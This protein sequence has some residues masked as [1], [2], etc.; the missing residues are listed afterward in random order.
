MRL[1]YLSPHYPRHFS[2]FPQ[3][4]ARY[5]VQVLGVS[6][7]PDECLE[8]SLRSALAGHYRVDGLENREQV[9]TA[10]HFFREHFGPFDRV[11]S[12]LEPWL[13]ME[14]VIREVFQVTGPK[15]ADLEFL[16]RKS[17]MKKVFQDARV[18][19]AR[20]TIVETIEQ[21][22][23]FIERRYPVFIKP[24]IG[25]GASDTYTI[26]S[27]DDLNYFFNNR[28][29]Y[30]Y[31]LEEYL[32]GVIESFDGL[33]DRE[34]NVVF[35]TSHVFS[36][37]IHQVVKK[38]ENLWYYSQREIPIDLHEA[39]KRVVKAANIREKF[40]HIEFFRVADGSLKA[41]EINLRPPGGLTTHMFNF[42]CDIDV[43]DWWARIIAGQS[44]QQSF[45]RRYHCA[46]LSR[47]HD[48]G[49]RHSVPDLR[50]R[51]GSGIVLEQPMN[52]IEFAVMGNVGF[53]VRSP[54]LAHL[55][56]MISSIIAE[57]S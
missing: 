36:N 13:E 54:D 15:P 50:S 37:D 17:L 52:P 32:S 56:E 18:P 14:G 43:Y 44:P 5:G 7:Q 8:P 35:C 38:N 49:Y 29:S 22:R 30:S 47:K 4:L 26:R 25:V 6:D 16:K 57:A 27:D 34:G 28:S 40:F 2:Q 46:F 53:L 55:K 24:D 3:S 20:G 12:H 1:V 48:R 9:L 23:S 41:L 42:A 31:F 10:C 45:D 21:C 19:V 33:T 39:G 11:E 51:F